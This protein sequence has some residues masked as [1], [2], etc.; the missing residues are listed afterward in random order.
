VFV[1]REGDN[2]RAA[3]GDDQEELRRL[4]LERF[5]MGAGGAAQPE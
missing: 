5:G 1:E 4:R 3:A 2:A